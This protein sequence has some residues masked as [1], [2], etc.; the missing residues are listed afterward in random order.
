[1]LLPLPGEY[2]RDI[3]LANHLALIGCGEGVGLKHS[4]NEL[5]QLAYLSFF[6]WEIGYGPERPDI[7]L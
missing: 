1:M 6:I 4:V 2:V 3:S 7:F 5:I